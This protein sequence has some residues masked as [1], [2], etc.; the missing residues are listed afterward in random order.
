[1][2]NFKTSKFLLD[3]C[4]AFADALVVPDPSDSLLTV[5]GARLDI[6]SAPFKPLPTE[7]YLKETHLINKNEYLAMGFDSCVEQKPIYQIDVFTPK[8]QGGKFP[9]E[10][11]AT[12]LEVEFKRG[13]IIFND[14]TQTIQISGV[15]SEIMG[16]NNT[17]NWTMIS[18]D[19]IVLAKGA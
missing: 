5:V 8:D 10:N 16:A 18:V 9:S 13:P 11:I 1:M 3:K 2:N 12:L 15:S 4:Q 7:T 17:H 14:G 19:L 6:Q